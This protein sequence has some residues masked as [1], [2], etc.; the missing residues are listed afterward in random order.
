MPD[1]GL[2]NLRQARAHR[3][4]P[5]Q[6]R[7]RGGVMAKKQHSLRRR[8]S[9]KSFSNALQVGLTKPDPF[10]TLARQCVS[11]EHRQRDEGG[12]D[13]EQSIFSDFK[14]PVFEADTLPGER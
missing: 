10:L 9:A 1:N 6:E 5:Q 14:L 13:A 2:L 3:F 7:E 4:L 12:G 11:L 8:Q